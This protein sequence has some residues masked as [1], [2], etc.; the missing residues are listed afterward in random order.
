MFLE[1]DTHPHRPSSRCTLEFFAAFFEGGW[2]GGADMAAEDKCIF[3][4]YRFSPLL[5]WQW[6]QPL[7]KHLL[8]CPWALHGVWMPAKKKNESN[9]NITGN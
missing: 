8:S 3:H 4:Y 6:E 5:C 7:L 1:Q 2:W 9:L